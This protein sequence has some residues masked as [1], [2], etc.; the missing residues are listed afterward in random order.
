MVI[1]IV[2]EGDEWVDKIVDDVI[3]V[4]FMVEYL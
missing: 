4:F 3:Y 1:V 2:E